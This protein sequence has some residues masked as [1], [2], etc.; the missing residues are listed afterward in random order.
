MEVTLVFNLQEQQ[1]LTQ[2]FDAA[3]RG[4]GVGMLDNIIYFRNKFQQAAQPKDLPKVE[5]LPKAAE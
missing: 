4:S 3:L 2:I 1:A 5:D